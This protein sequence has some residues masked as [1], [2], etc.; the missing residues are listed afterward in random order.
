MSPLCTK[1]RGIV[2]S[3]DSYRPISLT[4]VASKI[5]ER[6]ICNQIQTFWLTNNIMSV[7]QNSLWP[8]RLTTTNFV[9]CDAAISTIVKSGHS[10]DVILID[11]NKAFNKVPHSKLISKL[12]HMRLGK[13]VDEWISNFLQ[14]MS[15][16]VVYKGACSQ[17][18]KVTCGVI[19]SSVVRPLLFSA[20]I[21]DLPRCLQCGHMWLFVDDDK[22]VVQVDSLDEHE[23]FQKEF[24]SVGG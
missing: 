19:Q 23:I 22:T 2:K 21:N 5:L 16:T 17:P 18:C 8:S 10:C 7:E 15:Q 24:S 12:F 14:N 3:P 4:D 11:F 1:E 20:F 6:L 13:K 9:E